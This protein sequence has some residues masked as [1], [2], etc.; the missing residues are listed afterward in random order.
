MEYKNVSDDEFF[1][2]AEEEEAR[3]NYSGNNYSFEND[4]W[5]GME[6]GVPKIV[7]V[8]GGTPN[9]NTSDYTARI[10]TKCRIKDDNGKWM[11]VW[12][13]SVK[14]DP[15]YILNRIINRITKPS[16][17]NGQKTFPV[18][19]NYPEIYNIIE[20]NG[21]QETDPQYKFDRGWKGT[22]V[23]IMNVIDRENMA[24]HEENKHTMLLAKRVYTT[25]DGREIP[26]KGL[27]SF[28]VG[29]RISRLFGAYGNWEKYD[30]AFTKTGRKDNPYN[31]VNASQVPM[32]VD[33]AYQKYISTA[34]S[35]TDEEKTWEAYNIKEKF[36]PT[37]ASKIYNRLQQTIRKIDSALGT[38]FL[39]DLKDLMKAEASK[40]AEEDSY[41]PA[42][43]D[44]YSE[45]DNNKEEIP[46]NS[47]ESKDSLVEKEE[48]K[49]ETKVRTRAS[50][51]TE[52]SEWEKLPFGN[53][54]SDDMKK[55]ITKVEKE[56][57]NYI[58]T[59]DYPDEE[60]LR[61]PTCG[62]PAP[63]EVTKCPQCGT[64]F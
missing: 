2:F 23:I 16:W 47:E 13:P 39:D 50:A 21:L 54:L 31:V 37:S 25:E 43:V 5:T 11:E 14:E 49:V 45:N 48:P 4:K 60:L 41:T 56:G 22:E 63:A 27:S 18:Q 19:E 58:I 52:S 59:W 44:Y 7:R 6:T 53:T 29:T 17:Y 9:S 33:K 42:S 64:D 1:R 12:R 3:A 61:C 10:V 57:D 8:V 20:K 36:A 38:D 51:K 30:I 34:P 40:K 26:D 15:N 62:L 28:A 32:E 24:W 35:L 55:K 46:L